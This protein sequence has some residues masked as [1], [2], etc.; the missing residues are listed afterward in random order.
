MSAGTI[1]THLANMIPGLPGTTTPKTIF[2]SEDGVLLAYGT[3]VPADAS[4]G[5][6]PGCLFLHVDGGAGTALYVNEGTKA[7][8]N[9]DAATVS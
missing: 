9:F 4:V 7:S 5:F 8:S 3:V 6:S 1:A 2:A